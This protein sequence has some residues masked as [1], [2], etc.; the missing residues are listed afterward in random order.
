MLSDTASCLINVNVVESI[1]QFSLLRTGQVGLGFVWSP[2][3]LRSQTQHYTI[4]QCD[5]NNVPDTV[6]RLG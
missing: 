4:I 3:Y 6:E 5:V 2:T 1:I